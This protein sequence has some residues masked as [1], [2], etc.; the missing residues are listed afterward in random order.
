MVTLA[1]GTWVDV[2]A[3][4]DVPVQGSRIIKTEGGCLALFRTTGDEVFAL[5]DKCPHKGGPLS[6]G[7]VAGKTITC[8]LHNWMF[9][10]ESGE[11][12]GVDE[13]Q[14]ATTPARLKDGR[15]QLDLGGRS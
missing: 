1:I 12:L 8:P 6:Q 4:E 11:A 14:V 15:V 2:C 13:G 7:M 5:D 9:S 3:L 10:M